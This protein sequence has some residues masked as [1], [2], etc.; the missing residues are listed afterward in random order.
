LGFSARLFAPAV[1]II[2]ILVQRGDHLFLRYY[3]PFLESRVEMG[4]E[5]KQEF[6]ILM[7]C[8]SYCC[9]R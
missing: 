6:S 4:G 9:A 5:G 2:G 7:I 3:G 8:M 1:E